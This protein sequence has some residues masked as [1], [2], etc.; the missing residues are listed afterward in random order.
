MFLWML[1]MPMKVQESNECTCFKCFARDNAKS[2]HAWDISGHMQSQLHESILTA[3]ERGLERPLCRTPILAPM[4]QKEEYKGLVM[5][6]AME[7]DIQNCIQRDATLVNISKEK[8]R[9]HQNRF[10]SDI[11]LFKRNINFWNQLLREGMS[12]RNINEVI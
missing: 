12:K 9:C 11:F 7:D 3:R 6:H 1:F 5:M 8:T 2:K 4:R 10:M